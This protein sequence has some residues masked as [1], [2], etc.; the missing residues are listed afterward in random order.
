MEPLARG[1]C[2][3]HDLEVHCS[4]WWSQGFFFCVHRM[5]PMEVE[6]NLPWDIKHRS[7]WMNSFLALC[8]SLPHTV[9]EPGSLCSTHPRLFWPLISHLQDGFSELLIETTSEV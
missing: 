3:G 8:V 1:C 5:F 2:G 9:I 4:P 7:D 6:F